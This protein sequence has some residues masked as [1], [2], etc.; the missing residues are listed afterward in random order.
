M[1]MAP[2]VPEKKALLGGRALL[3]EV[4]HWRAL[5]REKETSLCFCFSA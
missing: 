4:G 1:K 2:I 5:G 3:E